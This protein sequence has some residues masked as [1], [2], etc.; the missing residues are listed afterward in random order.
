MS[1]YKPHDLLI[2]VMQL[3]IAY[4]YTPPV[5]TLNLVSIVLVKIPTTMPTGETIVTPE[6]L[7]H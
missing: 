7:D 4:H 2:R 1:L 3:S 5:V 6:A